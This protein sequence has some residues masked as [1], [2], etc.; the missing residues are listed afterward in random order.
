VLL[1]AEMTD[2][3]NRN[4][5]L[6]QTNY[7]VSCVQ[8]RRRRPLTSPSRSRS[9]ASGYRKG[10]VERVCRDSEVGPEV[11]LPK[12]G[13]RVLRIPRS[14][15][16]STRMQLYE[17]AQST[18]GTRE[19]FKPI[20]KGMGDE[21]LVRQ[22]AQGNER[23]LSELYD[24][25]SRPVYATGVRL[26]GDAHLAEDLVQDAFTNVWKGASSFDPSR[27]S[28][29]TWLYQITRNRAVDLARRRRVRPQSAGDDRLRA[30]SGGPEPEASVDDWDV[31]RA[32]SR[33]PE[34]H[35]EVLTLAYFEGLSQREI[36]Q[37][38]GVP[39]GTVKGRTTAALKRLHRNLVNPAGEEAQRG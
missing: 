30:I 28:F 3:L 4:G 2:L 38:T 36:S 21:E 13:R 25:Y 8:T 27:A 10:I 37:R 35:R 1:I 6:A 11:T 32:L 39:L 34:E 16:R 31:A 17:V 12:Q 33:I 26:L 14:D 18:P 15:R 7:R 23:A 20:V 19:T 9:G 29:T 5:V 22:V 24:R